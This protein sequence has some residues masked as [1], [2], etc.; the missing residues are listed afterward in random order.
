MIKIWGRRNSIN[1]MKVLWCA[2]E[3]ALEYEQIDAGMAFGVVTDDA[4]K[5]KN[6]NSKV[7]C[8]ED[9]DVVLWESNTMVRYLAA[10]YGLDTMCPSDPAQRGNAEKWMDWQLTTPYAD[11][12]YLFWGLVRNSPTHQD[13]DLQAEAAR[14]LDGHWAI[15]DQAL[16]GSEFLN[17]DQLS[18]ADIPLGCLVW[19]WKNLQ[20]QRAEFKHLDAWYERLQARAA[21]QKNVMLP[22]T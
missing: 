18:I 11:I 10:K 12:T 22:L 3:L 13:S 7:P 2:D 15:V 8:L 9:G 20:I 17:G 16:A 4:Y 21:Y 19:R 1:V 5:S 14:N 6:P